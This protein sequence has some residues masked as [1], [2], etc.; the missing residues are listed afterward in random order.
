MKEGSAFAFLEIERRMRLKQIL[1]DGL[2]FLR[3]S[4][5]GGL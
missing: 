5:D 4:T 1:S 2:I 3:I